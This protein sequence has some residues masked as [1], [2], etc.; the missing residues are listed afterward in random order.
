VGEGILHLDGNAVAGL[1]E[2]AFGADVTARRGWCDRCGALDPVGAMHVYAHAPGVVIRCRRCE[3]VMIRIVR[4]PSGL[5][6]DLR[7][8]R[9]LELQPTSE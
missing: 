3:S 2:E 4:L 6:I 1:L 7:G 5:R 8:T 9:S